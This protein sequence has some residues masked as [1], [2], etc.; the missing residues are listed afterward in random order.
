MTFEEIKRNK[1]RARYLLKVREAFE[2]FIYEERTTEFNAAVQDLVKRNYQLI[3]QTPSFMYK[4]KMYH[5]WNYHPTRGANTAIHPDMVKDVANVIDFEDFQAEIEQRQIMNY[6]GN[7]LIVSKNI[8]DLHA[9]IPSRMHA[10]IHY[11]QTDIYDIG[12]PM[13]EDQVA[14]FMLVNKAG[15][16]AFKRLFLLRLLLAK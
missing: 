15:L 10:P 3:G 13:S 16:S 9:I 14:Q 1:E 11:I 5:A 6:I 12:D 4:D 2:A 8:H 7:T